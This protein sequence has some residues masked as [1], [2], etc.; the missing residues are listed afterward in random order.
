MEDDIETMHVSFSMTQGEHRVS[1]SCE[2]RN[3]NDMKEIFR[4]FLL[5]CTFAGGTVE[6]FLGE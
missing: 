6:E 2:A 4:G 3:I 1:V 5:G